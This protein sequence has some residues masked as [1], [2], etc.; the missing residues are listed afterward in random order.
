MPNT[1]PPWANDAGRHLSASDPIF[2]RIVEQVGPVQI[3]ARPARFHALVRA[4]IFQQLAGAAATTIFN[5]FVKQIGGGRFPTP[6]RVLAATD[7]EMRACGLSR[8]KTL[9]LRDLATHVR[10]RRLNFH[11]FSGMEDEEIIIDLTRVKGIGRWTAEMFLMFNLH[12]PDVMPGGDLGL[13][14]ALAKAYG[15]D[16]P[17][18]PKE[19]VAFAERW[20][21]YRTAAA[22]Y[23]WQ[24]LRIITPEAT[25]AS[26]VSTGKNDIP[27]PVK[28]KALV[29]IK[30]VRKPKNAKSQLTTA[31]LVQK[32]KNVKTAA[33]KPK[34][35]LRRA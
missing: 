7:E 31:K 28:R 8:G 20:R 1:P 25:T 5:R 11:R 10:D 21:P 14:N 34:S 3:A 24:S 18:G 33:Q 22:W 29:K 17:P 35:S 19:I 27:A 2:A 4:I 23:L 6:A 12:R 15:M 13:R 16:K 30:L 32:L 26:K 9:Y